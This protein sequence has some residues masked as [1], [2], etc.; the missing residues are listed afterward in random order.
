MKNLKKFIIA[1]IFSHFILFSFSFIYTMNIGSH[2]VE[3]LDHECQNNESPLIFSQC[4]KLN[5]VVDGK[6]YNFTD[7]NSVTY[8]IT[9][10]AH[11]LIEVPNAPLALHNKLYNCP[12]SMDRSKA[13]DI[14]YHALLKNNV[15]YILARIYWLDVRLFGS[16]H[17]KEKVYCHD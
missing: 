17:F 11:F 8:A 7:L 6:T 10:F 16:K 5:I 9:S 13:D 2:T 15:N 12:G 14:F 4:S 3:F 1:L